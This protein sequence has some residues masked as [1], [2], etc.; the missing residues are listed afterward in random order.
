M[1]AEIFWPAALPSDPALDLQ[2]ELRRVGVDAVCRSLATRR[3]VENYAL[4]MLATPALHSFLKA[5]FEKLGTEAFDALRV[6]VRRL[7]GNGVAQTPSPQCIVF[8][9]AVTG[10]QF[11]FTADLPEEAFKQAIALDPGTGPGR[12]VWDGPQGAWTRA[13][14]R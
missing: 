13:E 3:G 4:V 9:S 12:W 6:C 7:L 14:G 2:T 1:E 5:V 10:S 11:V 8:E